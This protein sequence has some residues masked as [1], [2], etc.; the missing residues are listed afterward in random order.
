MPHSTTD[1][2][3]RRKNVFVIGH[4]P[5]NMP[6]LESLEVAQDINFIPALDK[7]ELKASEDVPAL[8]L[9]ETALKRIEDSGYEPDAVITYW[10]FPATIITAML[11]NR[12]NLIGPPL[13]SLFKCEHKAWSRMEQ[14]KVIYD[15]IPH[16][17]AFDPAD[18]DAYSKIN[19]VP[20]FWIKPVKSFRSYLSFRV[21]DRTDFEHYREEMVTHVG[22]IYGPFTD[23]MRKAHMPYHVTD[24]SDACI[25][26]SGL[27]GH[28][29]TVE[30]YIIDNEVICYGV[31]DSIR[32]TNSNS[33]L[34]YQYPSQLPMA[35]Q[36]RMMD[37]ARRV[38]AQI[39]L[40][41]SCFNIE[42]FYNQTDDSIYLLEINPR[43]SQ[44]HAD[45]FEKVHGQSQFQIMLQVA[46][47]ERPKPLERSGP[48]RLAAK[49][50]YRTDQP[51]VVKKLPGTEELTRLNERFPHTKI[52][53]NVREGDNLAELLFQDAY[54][55]EI[56]DIYIGG[57]DEMEI[58]AKYEE[59]VQELG[60]EIER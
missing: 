42:Y 47:G 45:L 2:R 41:D 15:N 29:C 54:S 20:P 50:M 1:R 40:N 27:S 36:Y 12:L 11:N 17:A 14:R 58:C 16:F 48:F 46:L 13:R 39:D 22:G 32:E 5:F 3:A 56:A 9:Y 6:M 23:L 10:D 25:A 35:V 43:T 52:N 18:P 51:G 26:E 33:F 49:Y 28:M 57:N 44:S 53:F 19:L 8:Q 7:D 21:E 4:D 55:F 30:G 60:V 37:I 31:V 59:I 24:S 34:R 38:L